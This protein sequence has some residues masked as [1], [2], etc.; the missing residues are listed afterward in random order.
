M[1]RACGGTSS[2]AGPP[3][4]TAGASRTPVP[5]SAASAVN[6][7]SDTSVHA[8][9]LAIGSWNDGPHSAPATTEVL[10]CGGSAVQTRT[11]RPASARQIPVV[12]P[13]T[14]A[15]TTTTDSAELCT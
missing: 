3:T 9:V 15:P 14:P 13:L 4:T 8:I 5:E 1:I 7:R 2:P 10:R 11:R 12:K 6:S